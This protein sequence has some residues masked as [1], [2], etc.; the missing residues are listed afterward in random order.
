[1]VHRESP[2]FFGESRRRN[3]VSENVGGLGSESTPEEAECVGCSAVGAS[4]DDSFDRPN[5]AGEEPAAAVFVGSPD[6]GR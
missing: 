1:V 5:G 4:S 6:G 3:L 2:V